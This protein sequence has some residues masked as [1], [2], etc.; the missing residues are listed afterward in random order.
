LLSPLGRDARL[1]FAFELDDALLTAWSVTPTTSAITHDL[2]ATHICSILP[3]SVI[4]TGRATVALGF[5]KL[6][7]CPPKTR[8]MP[9]WLLCASQFALFASELRGQYSAVLPAF[10]STNLRMFSDSRN[11]ENL[12]RMSVAGRSPNLHLYPGAGRQRGSRH[13]L[14]CV[15]K[16]T[17]MEVSR[18][19]KPGS[20]GNAKQSQHEERAPQGV[21]VLEAMPRTRVVIVS[22][23]RL[24]REG[25][26]QL[27][28]LR[29]M[30]EL[31]L[32]CTTSIHERL[33]CTSADVVILDMTGA[34]ML[35]TIR[36]I[37]QHHPNVR[38]LALGV[39]ENAD[40][41]VACAE[42]G[43]AGFLSYESGTEELF[44]VLASIGRD[45]LWCSPRAAAALFR[46]HASRA[47]PP[48]AGPLVMLTRRE[49]EVLALV[50]EG[51][52]NKE[53]ATRLRL[54]VTTVK[55]HVHGIL[56]KLHV[57]R[58]G[59]AAALLHG[60]ERVR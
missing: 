40:D 31:E 57:H 35:A 2:G 48:R 17:R 33:D 30:H 5:D 42:A 32:T 6:S 49:Q 25:I 56:E 38:V 15:R 19:A 1:L 3:T 50:D 22:R 37:R 18:M 46:R 44:T 11:P 7:A 28:A 54:G 24:L 26:G 4:T 12:L 52:S 21:H 13:I 47:A 43:A 16:P 23:V 39:D 27:L 10:A 34:D 29:G 58:R 45:E 9:S 14:R 51:L 55:N 36:R 41:L 53:I 8:R 59:A 20:N 60:M